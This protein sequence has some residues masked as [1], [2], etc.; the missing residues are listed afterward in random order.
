MSSTTEP[1]IGSLFSGVG[2]LDMGVQAVIGGTVVWHVEHA[3]A[4]SKIL[5]HHWPDVPNY[6]DITKVDWAV[7]AKEAPVDV[8]TGGFP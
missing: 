1:R 8:L 3:A 6:G 2:G 4:P 7:I 5:A